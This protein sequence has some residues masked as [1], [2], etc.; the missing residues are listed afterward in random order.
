MKTVL[1]MRHAKSS[2]KE[3]GLA[4]WERPLNKRGLADAPRMGALLL[5]E[6]LE[7]QAI[8]SSSARR[9][10]QTAEIVAEAVGYDGDIAYHDELYGATSAH[11]LRVLRQLADDVDLVLVIGHNP[12][13]EELVELLTAETDRLPTAAI[14]QL[15]LPIER[16]AEAWEDVEADLVA[17]WRPRELA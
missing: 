6:G 2:W 1:L 4:D 15:Q 14:A 3:P 9:A 13:L 8:V 17:I 11:Y 5:E 10:Q 16:W 12:E 7:P